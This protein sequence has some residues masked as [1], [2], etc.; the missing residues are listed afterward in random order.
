MPE[1]F[2][3]AV[4]SRPPIGDPR[5]VR[6]WLPAYL[7]RCLAWYDRDVAQALFERVRAD[8]DHTNDQVLAAGRMQDF[9]DWALLDPR[10][11]TARLE[12]VP[13]TPQL[14]LN[15]DLSRTY[16]AEILGLPYEQR[17]RKVLSGVTYLSE[18]YERDIRSSP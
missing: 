10:A 16:V 13:V 15:A 8:L 17:L 5:V 12:K 4:A 7:V 9:L 18:L 2:W 11:A 14:E 3:R 6:E 1:L